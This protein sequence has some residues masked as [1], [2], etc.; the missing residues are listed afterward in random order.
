[1]SHIKRLCWSLY[2]IFLLIGPGPVQ[3]DNSREGPITNFEWLESVLDSVYQDL[4]NQSLFSEGDRVRVEVLSH[5]TVFSA[6]QE[7]LLNEMSLAGGRR[8]AGGRPDPL[9]EYKKLTLRWVEWSVKYLQI[10]DLQETYQRNLRAGFLV[11]VTDYPGEEIVFAQKYD[12]S[13]VDRLSKQE[14]EGVGND[15]MPFTL[16]NKNV[17]GSSRAP[18]WQKAFLFAISAAVVY[19]FYSVRTQ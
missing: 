11:E 5:D 7:T 8:V 12:Y 15:Q 4:Q 9:S 1:M 14:L 10:K 6:V 19:L 16:E 17:K 2:I 13:L 18:L 3:S